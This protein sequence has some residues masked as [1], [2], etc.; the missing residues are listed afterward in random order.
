MNRWVG[1]HH[2][3]TCFSREEVHIQ[4]QK[5]R[6]E[7]HRIKSGLGRDI[8][9]FKHKTFRY[10]KWLVF[11]RKFIFQDASFV[12]YPFVSF[13]LGCYGR[14]QSAA[15]VKLPCPGELAE[16]T[17]RLGVFSVGPVWPWLFAFFF[18]QKR[19]DMG[20]PSSPL[21]QYVMVHVSQ[22]F[23]KITGLII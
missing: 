4:H 8:Q 22:G 10:Q 15:F 7:D 12:G 18:L 23:F 13:S 11:N 6:S 14:R 19:H 21:C 5:G 2:L 9:T 17:R 1:F 16:S 20:K 3:G